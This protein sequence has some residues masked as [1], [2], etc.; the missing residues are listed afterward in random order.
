MKKRLSKGQIW[1]TAMLWWAN[2]GQISVDDEYRWVAN[3][4]P[5]AQ[6]RDLK[7]GLDI[8]YRG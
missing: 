6:W 2:A 3:S 7:H 8:Y 4:T 1:F 5:T